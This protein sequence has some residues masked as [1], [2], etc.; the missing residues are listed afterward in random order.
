MF[1]ES[2]ATYWSLL[3]SKMILQRWK[4]ISDTWIGGIKP[5]LKA[6]T[7]G[8]A[9]FTISV[10]CFVRYLLL[11]LQALRPDVSLKH[12]PFLRLQTGLPVNQDVVDAALTVAEEKGAGFITFLKE[13]IGQRVKATDVVQLFCSLCNLDQPLEGKH[14]ICCLP[15]RC[16]HFEML[17]SW[18]NQ[19]HP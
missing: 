6:A 11:H 3:K 14:S 12:L 18:M 17:H 8:S 5:F 16:R 19:W 9:N 4:W 2:V 1:S 15:Q 7:S 10:L 13:Q